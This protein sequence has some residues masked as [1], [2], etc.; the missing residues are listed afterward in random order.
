MCAVSS[1]FPCRE[2]FLTLGFNRSHL[3]IDVVDVDADADAD[4]GTSDP[5]PDGTLRSNIHVGRK[6]R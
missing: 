2:T 3:R 5:D 4:A 6:S 1:Q